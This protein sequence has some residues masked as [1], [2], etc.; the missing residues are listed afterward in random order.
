M[1]IGSFKFLLTR[2]S[3]ETVSEQTG[4]TGLTQSSATEA[5]KMRNGAESNLYEIVSHSRTTIEY[6]QSNI[7]DHKLNFNYVKYYSCFD[8][9]CD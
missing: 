3:W 6:I 5:W 1:N 8:Q 9:V 4:L 2:G 7:K